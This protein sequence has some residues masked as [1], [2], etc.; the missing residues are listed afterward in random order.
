MQKVPSEMSAGIKVAP[1]TVRI[2]RHLPGPVERLWAY[3]TESEKRRQ[4]LAAGEMEL[5]AGGRVEL[6][7]RHHELSHEQMP[8]RYR[9]AASGE[10]MYGEIIACDPPRLLTFSWPGDNGRSEVTFELTP[11]GEDVCLVVTHRRLPDMEGMISVA[12]GWEA[13]L[14]ILEDRLSGR[15]P[16]GFWSTHKQLKEEYAKQFA[17]G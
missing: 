1:D 16:R 11:E 10:P 14:G 8:D 15:Q 7:F 12:S 9:D 2:E 3:L 6:R 13:H 4:W 17:A 5:F